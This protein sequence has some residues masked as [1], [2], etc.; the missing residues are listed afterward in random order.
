MNTPNIA[1]RETGNGNS[2]EMAK[3][4]A[5]DIPTH[6][7]WLRIFLIYLVAMRLL[8]STIDVARRN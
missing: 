4:I 6:S 7:S 3:L 1:A 8:S 2:R 5:N